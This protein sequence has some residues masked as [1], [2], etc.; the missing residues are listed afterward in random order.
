MSSVF[1]ARAKILERG[2]A[3][4]PIR[5]V[6]C[7]SFAIPQ[8]YLDVTH[9]KLSSGQVPSR[10]VVGL[11]T[12]QAFNGH[13]ERNPFNFQHSTWTVSN[14]MPSDPYSR[15]T[16]TGCIYE[17]TIVCLPERENCVKT[18]DYIYKS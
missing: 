2:T 18:N 13:A 8:H 16:N 3:K 5:R 6:V 10:V 7:K 14:S 11:V 15:I 17:P 9:E 1:L 4:Y 12:N